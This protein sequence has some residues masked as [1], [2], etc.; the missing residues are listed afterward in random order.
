MFSR[1]HYEAI[2][3]VLKAIRPGEPKRQTPSIP[4]LIQYEKDDSR[5]RMYRE[6]VSELENMFAHDNPRFDRERF[7]R[8]TE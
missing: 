6:I 7:V 4:E 2:A 5:C 3:S 1:K 8:A